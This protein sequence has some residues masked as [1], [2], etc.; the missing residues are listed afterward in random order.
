MKE[1]FSQPKNIED[2]EA[3]KAHYRLLLEKHKRLTDRYKRAAFRDRSTGTGEQSR[4]AD[5][6]LKRH[7]VHL[8][9]LKI[10]RKLGKNSSDVAVD[11][12]ALDGSL[13]EYQINLPVMTKEQLEKDQ[14]VELLNKPEILQDCQPLKEDE[15]FIQFGTETYEELDSEGNRVSTYRIMQ[16]DQEPVSQE[17]S[18]SAGFGRNMEYVSMLANDFPEDV[19]PMSTGALIFHGSM[20][21]YGVALKKSGLV[22]VLAELR[23]RIEADKDDKSAPKSYIIS[24]GEDKLDE[25]SEIR[26]LPNEMLSYQDLVERLGEEGAK[27]YVSARFAVAETK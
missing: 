16:E 18:Y 26:R 22:D 6:D 11:L 5:L 15:V 2:I 1:S 12:L 21:M 8:E 23:S 13:K 14:S 24:A 27:R 9:L 4:L 10:A 25:V 7:E 17:Y 20:R 3:E 19:R